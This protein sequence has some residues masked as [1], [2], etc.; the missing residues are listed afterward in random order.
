MQLQHIVY[1]GLP[2][3]LEWALRGLTHAVVTRVWGGRGFNYPHFTEHESE[4]WRHQVK[5][6]GYMCDEYD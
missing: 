3:K 2:K 4:T 1:K 6:A 5:T